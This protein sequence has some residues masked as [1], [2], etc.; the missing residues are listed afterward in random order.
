MN[1]VFKQILNCRH[2]EGLDCTF[3]DMEL[4]S[5][6]RKGFFCSWLFKCLVCQIKIKIDSENTSE[7][8]YVGVN[9]AAVSGSI[10]IGIGHT[11]TNEF[12]ASIDVP[13]ISPNVFRLQSNIGIEEKKLAIEDGNINSDGIPMIT[14]V[15]D[16]SW[17][18]GDSS[19]CKRLHQTLPYGPKLLVD[20]IECRNHIL[21]NLGQKI[22]QLIKNTKYPVH[23]R[24]LLNQKQ[25][26]NKFRTAITM[27][28]QYRKL[29]C[30]S[31]VNK[32]KDLKKDIENGPSH[33]L[34]Q[35]LN[36]ES[37]FCN[38]S[39]IGEQNVVPEAEK[40]GLM[41]EISQIYHRVVENAQSL[42]L[43]VD[44]NICE[45][46]NSI[47]NKHIAGKRIN[48]ALKNSYNARVEAAVVSFNISG[49]YIRS[50]HKKITK[51]SPGIVGKQ[52]LKARESKLSSLQERRLNFQ[53]EKYT[54]KRKKN[55]GPDE[56]YGLAE[57][58]DD[59]ETPG[60]IDE[61]KNNFMKS[62]TIDQSNSQA[63]QVER[64][65]RLTASNFGRVCKMRLTTSCKGTV[66]DLLYGNVTTKAMEYGKIMEDIARKKFETLT[67][68]KVLNCGLFIDKDKPYLAAS[69]DGLV[70][71]TALLE[72]K[73]PL[74]IKDT[75]DIQVAVDNKKIPYITIVDGKMKLKKDSSYYYQV[76][77]QLKITKRK[78][79][80]H[81]SIDK[82]TPEDWQNFISHVKTEEQKMWNVDFISD[83][84]TDE[85]ESN[86]NHV[87]TIGDN[88]N[89]SKCNVILH[90]GCAV[91]RESVFRNMSKTAEQKWSCGKC[92]SNEI[93][94]NQPGSKVVSI[95][96]H[97]DTINVNNETINNLVKS[98]N[99]MS[100][101]FDS[102]GK[103]LQ[104]LV[105]TINN[106]KVENSFLKE[107]NCKLKNEVALLDKRMNIFE[108]KAIE[109]YVEIVG[110]P[111]VNNEDCI[112]T[113]ES[114]VAAVG[115]NIFV[116]KA[117]HGATKVAAIDELTQLVNWQLDMPV[118]SLF[119]VVELLDI[120]QTT[121]NLLR[122][123]GMLITI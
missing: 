40:C 45:Q 69:R 56:H 52:F 6:H 110:V 86:P 89:C 49:Q 72:I 103:Q 79:L 107:E 58:L 70:G 13:C 77:G 121:M 113:V 85:L 53:K 29:L 31:E 59:N 62:D 22:S 122:N 46:F 73:C 104:E 119:W 34:G 118:S 63:W 23:L 10:T 109:K 67:N 54:A 33:L 87:L 102:L 12:S 17:W 8:E 20:K 111:E 4:I 74:S 27:A 42:L 99:F 18:D 5:E 101:K 7:T 100:D 112:K 35:H 83:E 21:K 68:F 105:T 108:Q 95:S 57:P 1:F 97:S 80:L 37:Y 81:Q 88:I 84:L 115:A 43:D 76:Q 30:D 3:L 2:K 14:V 50:I 114:I 36:C 106:I 96:T 98:V 117:F 65:I 91:F 16:G 75:I 66:Y 9:K 123:F 32:I 41:S 78:H 25:K 44:N 64:R 60:D 39:K 26:C 48:F 82:V 92:K 116:L 94:L 38:G 71:D 19:V 28:I 120:K 93:Y 15:A 55:F 90:L 47:I 51:K 11:Q 24:N 61:K